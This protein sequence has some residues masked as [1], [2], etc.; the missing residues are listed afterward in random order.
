MIKGIIFDFDG[1]IVDSE[2]LYIETL[3][4]YLAGLGVK[5]SEEKISYVIGQNLNDIGSDIISQ[6]GLNMTAEEFVNDSRTYYF[7]RNKNAD[8]PLLPGIKEF[9]ER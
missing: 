1:V 3:L 2:P 4:E 7:Q 5:T 9:I 8:Y 6:F